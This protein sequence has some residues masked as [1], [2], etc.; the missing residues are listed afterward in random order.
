M[1]EGASGLR[2]G[3]RSLRDRAE[4]G[5]LL[6][7]RRQ[8]APVATRFLLLSRG[9][10]GTGRKGETDGEGRASI[11][12]PAPSWT[13]ASHKVA[14]KPELVLGEAPAEDGRAIGDERA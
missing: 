13:F 11:G 7:S 14:L 2:M 1:G 10:G 9:E 12:E 8:A 5:L 3:Y 4:C 6:A